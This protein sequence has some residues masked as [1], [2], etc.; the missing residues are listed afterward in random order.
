MIQMTQGQALEAGKVVN[1]I[2]M[3]PD[4][5]PAAGR[6]VSLIQMTLQA[7]EKVASLVEVLAL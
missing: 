2:Q 7:S 6:E 3:I 5:V 1:M 4:L